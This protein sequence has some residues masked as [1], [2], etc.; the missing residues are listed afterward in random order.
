M[1]Q[2]FRWSNSALSTLQQCGEKFRR[3]YI[4]RER[5]PS[6]LRQMRG[7]VI[8]KTAA[9]AHRRQIEKAELPSVE[10]AR[11]TAATELDRA[12][13]GGVSLLPEEAA[14]GARVVKDQTK[15][16][17]VGLSALHVQKVAPAIHPIGVEYRV[18][19]KP[20]GADFE[21][22]GVIDL[23]DEQPIR[24]LSG[25]V[26][27]GTVIRDLK[28][29][30]K[31]P[32]RGEASDSQ[33]LTMYGML[34]WAH[35]GALPGAYV[36]DIL[37]QTPERKI[38]SHVEQE[39]TRTL[40]DVGALVGRLNVAVEAVRKGVFLPTD[41]SNWWCS[42]RWCEFHSTCPYVRRGTSRPLA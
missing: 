30:E 16:F 4:E 20:A 31:S 33:Q 21:I 8:H 12:W 9:V 2:P 26:S 22:V 11:D 3:R 24:D 17:V 39:T 19:V 25:V 13:Q 7:T 28:S 35:T 15:D 14:L 41:P 10:E 1:A 27:A 23:V 40:D 5:V 37:V 6:S 34:W 38:R 32:Q 36:L 18:T 42:A 29:R